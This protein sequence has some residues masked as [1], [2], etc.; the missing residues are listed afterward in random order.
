[1]TTA[2]SHLPNA[3]YIDLILADV[4]SNPE[5][6]NA[7]YGAARSAA[8]SAARGAAWGAAWGAARDAAIGAILALI[9][10]DADAA[11]GAVLAL[12]AYDDCVWL[13]DEKPEHVQMLSILGESPA[14]ILLY[15]AVIARQ[16]E[17]VL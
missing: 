7:A 5:R 17:L 14:A 11:Y 1:M 6:W 15:P 13:L 2:W 4:K 12:I 3:K 16:K 9:A 10:Y 8:R